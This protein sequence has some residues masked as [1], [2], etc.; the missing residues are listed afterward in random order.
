MKVPMVD[1]LAGYPPV[2]DEIETAVKNVFNKA[3]FIL[4][5][6]VSKFEKEFALHNGTKY[7]VGV[8]NGTDALRL[9]II[10]CGVKPGDEVITSPFTFIATTET[11]SQ[12]G[13]IPVFADI[14][15]VTFNLDP[16]SVEGK[17]TKKTKAIIPVHLYGMPCDMDAFTA[18]AKNHGLR[19]IEDTAQAFTGKY[20]LGSGDWKYL[21]SIG[22]CGT[23]S[24]FPAKNLGA[25]GDGGAVT[26]ND[27]KIYEELKAL[28][29]HGSKVRYMHEIEG[30]NSR[31][32]TV[33]AA[34]L[35]VRLKHVE[36]WTEMRNAV[37]AKYAEALKGVCVT[38]VV[39]ANARHSFNYYTLRFDSKIKRDN[40]QKHLTEQQIANQIYYPI[41]LHLQKAYAHLGGKKGDL[42]VCELVQDT[43]FSLPMYPELTDLQIK[44]VTDAV[45]KAV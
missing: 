11:I 44:T 28:R 34:V 14:D 45:K 23:Y 43:V 21:G 38:P 36:K 18:L 30:F 42:P 22:D 31:L 37:A 15:P 40:A 5:E 4:G 26:T 33:Q 25:F 13:A 10:A 24:F 35:S 29:N 7:A 32:D 16:K 17:I 9:S 8:A 6:E 41:S 2:K 12:C 20:K 39:P 1:M 19:I 27:D 3:N